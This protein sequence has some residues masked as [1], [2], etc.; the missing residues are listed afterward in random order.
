L[1]DPEQYEG[2]EFY[3]YKSN[4]GEGKAL[5]APKQ[6]GVVLTWRAEKALDGEVVF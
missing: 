4:F 5:Q 3:Y 6:K 1:T 2:G